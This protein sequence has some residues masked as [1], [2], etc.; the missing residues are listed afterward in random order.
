MKKRG[1]RNKI[2]G[3]RACERRKRERERG[4]DFIGKSS[5][6]IVALNSFEH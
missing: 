5:Q 1:S 6:W 4:R 2:R 3:K